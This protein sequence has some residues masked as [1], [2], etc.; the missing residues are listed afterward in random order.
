VRF[1]PETLVPEVDPETCESIV[2]GLFIAG[3]LQAGRDTGRIFI[4]NSREHAARIAET[5]RRRL[6]P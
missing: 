5:V 4:E 2:P 1:D 6:R 3:T